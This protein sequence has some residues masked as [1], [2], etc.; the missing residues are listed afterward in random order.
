M[1][2]NKVNLDSIMLGIPCMVD[3]RNGVKKAFLYFLNVIFLLDIAQ[4][5]QKLLYYTY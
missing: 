5:N 4:S 3:L 2:L 1:S